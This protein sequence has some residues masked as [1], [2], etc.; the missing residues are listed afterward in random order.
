MADSAVESCWQAEPGVSICIAQDQSHL[1]AP[2]ARRRCSYL[3][4]RANFC[5]QSR[6][7]WWY[8]VR[9]TPHH[10]GTYKRCILL[11]SWYVYLLLLH[12]ERLHET[13]FMKCFASQTSHDDQYFHTLVILPFYPKRRGSEIRSAVEPHACPASRR[14]PPSPD[15]PDALTTRTNLPT[16]DGHDALPWRSQP[17]SSCG[18]AW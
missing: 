5:L 15:W 13:A 11:R 17:I 16:L 1:D 9:L 4:I 14:I 8:N 7:G 18:A 3:Q 12:V 10:C 6:R 2:R